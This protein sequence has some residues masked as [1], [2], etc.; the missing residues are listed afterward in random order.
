MKRH[1]IFMLILM[2]LMVVL[3]GSA[4]NLTNDFY[5]RNTSVYQCGY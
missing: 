1:M 4:S 3:I 5:S 2:V